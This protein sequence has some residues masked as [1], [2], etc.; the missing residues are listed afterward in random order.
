MNRIT[1]LLFVTRWGPWA[2]AFAIT[3]ALFAVAAALEWAGFR[4]WF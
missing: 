2:L 4:L 3:S 1:E